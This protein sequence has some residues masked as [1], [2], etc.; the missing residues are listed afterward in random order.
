MLQS[1][2]P[3]CM[4]LLGDKQLPLEEKLLKLNNEK[5]SE[6]KKIEKK[7]Q[8]LED[9]GFELYCC[10]MRATTYIDQVQILV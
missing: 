10:K 9:L 7:K 6:Q 4:N 2:C 3:T 1:V 8:I 5:I